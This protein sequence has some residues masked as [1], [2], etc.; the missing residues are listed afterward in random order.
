MDKD[1]LEENDEIYRSLLEN[2]KDYAKLQLQLFKL[3]MVEKSSQILSFLIVII[4]GTLLLMTAFVYFSMMFVV[5]IR[6]L[7]GSL[8]LGFLSVGAIFVVLFLV[9]FLV[10][11]KLIINPIIRKMSAILFSENDTEKEEEDGE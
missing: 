5:W 2:S 9:F 4:A 3:N 1:F 7:T 6:Q 11:K 10:R 8:S